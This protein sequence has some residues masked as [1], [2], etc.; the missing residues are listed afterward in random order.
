MTAADRVRANLLARR[1]RYEAKRK[2]ARAASHE[3]RMAEYRAR[4]AAA[5]VA[6]KQPAPI[7]APAH[8]RPMNS[9]YAKRAKPAPAPVIAVTVEDYIAQGGK[10][11]RIESRWANALGRRQ[12]SMPN[13]V[14]VAA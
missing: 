1:E 11:E 10:V 6:P 2:A 3:Q 14:S 13:R 4:K 8:R 5:R 12:P 9:D 7:A